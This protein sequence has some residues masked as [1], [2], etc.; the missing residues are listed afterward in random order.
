MALKID[1]DGRFISGDCALGVWAKQNSKGR[2]FYRIGPSWND[3][4]VASGLAPAKFAK[5]FW[6]RDDFE[7]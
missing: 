7:E 3:T 2:W 6:F 5:S 4:L 1:E